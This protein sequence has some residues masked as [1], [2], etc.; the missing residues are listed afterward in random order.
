MTKYAILAATGQIGQLTTQYLFDNSSADLVLFGHDVE[1]RLKD[2]DGNR[3]SF[4]NGDLKDPDALETALKDVDAVFLAYVATP[5]IINPLIKVMDN[6]GVN[7][8]VVMSVPDVYEEVAGPF[9]AWYR[10]HTGE[11]L[12]TKI[13]KLQTIHLVIGNFGNQITP[14]PFAH[15][16]QV[17]MNLRTWKRKSLTRLTIITI[18]V[19]TMNHWIHL[20]F[21]NVVENNLYLNGFEQG[22][23]PFIA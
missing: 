7:R 20:H 8:L 18:Q 5:D 17:M 4:V 2:F 1:Q 11:Q 14:L 16:R 19:L 13:H 22:S 10:E 6:S 3:V 15:H 12:I 23:S 21:S 9:Q